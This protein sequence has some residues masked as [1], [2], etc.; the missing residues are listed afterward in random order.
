M[1]DGEEKENLW[2]PL[3]DLKHPID[4]SHMKDAAIQFV[5]T[6]VFRNKKSCRTPIV[7]LYHSKRPATRTKKMAPFHSG[8]VPIEV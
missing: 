4:I 6:D 2:S 1:K 3:Q 5:A 8:I 7:W